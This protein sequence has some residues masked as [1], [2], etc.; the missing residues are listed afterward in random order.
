[1]A[2]FTPSAKGTS[3]IASVFQEQI[4]T[5]S[6]VHPSIHSHLVIQDTRL[7]TRAG[8][9]TDNLKA[10]FSRPEEECGNGFVRIFMLGH[11][12]FLSAISHEGPVSWISK[13]WLAFEVEETIP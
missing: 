6:E 13:V 9:D 10:V 4:W 7:S 12:H 1:M 3:T 11:K 2:I 5:T 8:R